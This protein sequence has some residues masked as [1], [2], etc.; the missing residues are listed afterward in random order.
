LG[1]FLL[2]IMTRAIKN[3][4]VL[5]QS[6][7]DVGFVFETTDVMISALLAAWTWPA[8]ATRHPGSGQVASLAR[9]MKKALCL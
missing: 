4:V 3:N 5:A 8:R 7:D 9:V 1:I 2:E 6:G